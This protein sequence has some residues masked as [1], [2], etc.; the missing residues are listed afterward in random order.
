MKQSLNSSKEMSM[1][2]SSIEE[3]LKAHPQLLE[4]IEALLNVVEKT[5]EENE[6]ADLA[7]QRVR[8]EVRNIGQQALSS[9]A[10]SQHQKQLELLRENNPQ[11]RKHLKK[12]FTGTPALEP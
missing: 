7:E 3:R 5:G 12:N 2:K 1:A 9:W 6:Q 8:E 4:R 11:A 10:N